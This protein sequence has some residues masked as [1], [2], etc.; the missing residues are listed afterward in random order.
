M[1][2]QTLTDPYKCQQQHCRNLKKYTYMLTTTQSS[3]LKPWALT[4]MGTLAR[5]LLVNSVLKK[6]QLFPSYFWVLRCLMRWWVWKPT[7]KGTAELNSLLQCNLISCNH[8]GCLYLSSS[9]KL[10]KVGPTKNQFLI[11]NELPVYWYRKSAC[12]SRRN[13]FNANIQQRGW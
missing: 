8:P 7:K 13:T 6:K 2:R 11:F 12:I 3:L 5:I 9:W 1:Q 10:P 4:S